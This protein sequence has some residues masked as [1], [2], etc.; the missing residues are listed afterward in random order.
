[1]K[2]IVFYI[3]V[4]LAQAD[5]FWAQAQS[6]FEPC[7]YQQAIKEMTQQYPDYL[8]V[9]HRTFEIAKMQGNTTQRSVSKIP[10]IVHIV[11]KNIEENLSDTIVAQQ[12]EVL[13]K[14]FRRQNEDANKLRYIFRNVA[15]DAM[16]EFELKAI[17]RKETT[18]DFQPSLFSLAGADAVKQTAKGGDD[19]V[20]PEHFLNIWVCNVK[21]IN[22]LGSQSPLLGY[23]YPPADLKNWPANSSAPTK[24]LDGVVISYKVFG[25]NK[26]FEMPQL[27]TL[28]IKGKTAVHEVGHYLGLRHI[29]GDGQSAL[30][31][32]KDC[33]AD[34]G[35]AD[36]PR[37]GAQS[38]F[39]CDTL[40]NN[41]PDTP[42]DL[43]DMVEN[44]M[45]YAAETCTNTFTAGQVAIMQG[46]LAGPR[47]GLLET[48]SFT[49]Q[50]IEKGLF[51]ASPNPVNDNLTLNL[52][53]TEATEAII[54]LYDMLGRIVIQ[55]TISA[56]S[57]DIDMHAL[58]PGTYLI[59]VQKGMKIGIKKLNKQ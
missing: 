28:E 40:R 16:I 21:P 12:I 17:K 42:I 25:N 46:V 4:F 26:T 23:A 7:G 41:C 27:G 54:E 52:N 8:D 59:K 30:L 29:W 45:D 14:A 2:K 22:I 56:H 32:G 44:Y 19:A 51:T 55:K 37:S 33:K 10:V 34:D 47:R 49:R 20:D 18:A 24:A 6:H 13:N 35:V 38:Q 58:T 48:P 5:S 50:P 31:G 39:N 11:W 57:I 1:M 3:I 9:T 15:A 43:P 53:D 36:T